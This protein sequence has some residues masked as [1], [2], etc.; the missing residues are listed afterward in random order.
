M[1]ELE[2]VAS[3]MNHASMEELEWAASNMNH[4]IIEW[5]TI[6]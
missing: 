1:E 3:N 5:A 4:A 6:I 2:W